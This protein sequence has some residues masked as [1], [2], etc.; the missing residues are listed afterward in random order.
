MSIDETEAIELNVL[1]NP[2]PGAKSIK[3]M[4]NFMIDYQERKEGHDFDETFM[5]ARGLNR[6]I[7]GGPLASHD[8]IWDD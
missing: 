4:R 1:D 2:P 5:N 3:R 8:G 7:V 6:S